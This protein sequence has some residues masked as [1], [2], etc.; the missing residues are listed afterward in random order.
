MLKEGYEIRNHK[1]NINHNPNQDKEKK[2]I[3]E[4]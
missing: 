2:N 3:N 1:I 4:S